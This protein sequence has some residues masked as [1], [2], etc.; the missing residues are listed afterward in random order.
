MV[1]PVL[2]FWAI[3]MCEEGLFDMEELE[4][5]SGSNDERDERSAGVDLLSLERS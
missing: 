5:L 4:S 3:I 2:V 1:W